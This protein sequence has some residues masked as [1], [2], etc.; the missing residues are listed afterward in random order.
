MKFA[1]GD[2]HDENNTQTANEDELV[3]GI[4]DESVYAEEVYLG[5]I[6]LVV[7]GPSVIAAALLVKQGVYPRVQSSRVAKDLPAH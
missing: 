2:Q 1:L 4:L 5:D 7:A 3:A 6:F